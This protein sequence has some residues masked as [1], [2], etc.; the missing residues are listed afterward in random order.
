MKAL[1]PSNLPQC[2]GSLSQPK[3][4]EIQ[5]T[6]KTPNF[7]VP[8]AIRFQVRDAGELDNHVAA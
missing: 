4:V 6:L 7:L 8:I 3:R 2:F 1:F 5:P